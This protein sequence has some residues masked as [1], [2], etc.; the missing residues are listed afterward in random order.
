[1]TTQFAR[2]LIAACAAIAVYALLAFV[3]LPLLIA[4]LCAL[5]ACAYVLT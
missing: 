4:G 1:M 2:V 5:L 3:G